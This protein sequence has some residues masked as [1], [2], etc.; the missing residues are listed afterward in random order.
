MPLDLSSAFESVATSSW[1]DGDSEDGSGDEPS[2]V[3]TPP[4]PHRAPP[5]PS[6]RPASPRSLS[7]RERRELAQRAQLSIQQHLSRLAAARRQ[8]SNAAAV[9][10][11][12]R[13]AR[14]YSD[15]LERAGA[16]SRSFSA[17]AGVGGSS[18]S[19]SGAFSSTSSQRP[20]AGGGTASS[21]ATPGPGSYGA[22]LD[23]FNRTASDSRSKS[24]RS[25][26]AAF[27]ARVARP[28]GLTNTPIQ[29]AG[30]NGHYERGVPKAA[31]PG[32]G[33]YDAR[34][35]AP[36]QAWNSLSIRTSRSE[37]RLGSGC[38]ATRDAKGGYLQE[39]LRKEAAAVPDVFAYDALDAQRK[40]VFASCVGTA[41]SAFRSS[42]IRFGAAGREARARTPPLRGEV[43]ADD[44]GLTMA[45]ELRQR[46]RGLT[47]SSRRD[48]LF[49]RCDAQLPGGPYRKMVSG[50][51]GPF[52]RER[53]PSPRLRSPRRATHG[54][55][56]AAGGASPRSPPPP[57]R[58]R[59]SGT[60]AARP[61]A[62]STTSALEDGD[63]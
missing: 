42:D 58:R 8:S 3:T 49:E 1:G 14:A 30:L 55:G 56:G 22:G 28:E 6:T 29:R 16:A 17:A 50:G 59:R 20:N 53:T 61:S 39:L 25:G 31:T 62:T 46:L 57:R 60:S 32:P 9:E 45:S 54:S 40:A 12:A 24:S 2:E 36:R 21:L 48:D 47:R 15:G 63:E 27:G 7:A 4:S 23:L 43:G 5:R 13:A 26:A 51:G 35:T 38:F 41:Q 44:L 10:W 33:E 37:S 18:S 34:V 19:G 52:V 11:A